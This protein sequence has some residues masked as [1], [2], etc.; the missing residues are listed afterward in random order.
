MKSS[1]SND[2]GLLNINDK[3]RSR[4]LADKNAEMIRIARAALSIEMK[5]NIESMTFAGTSENQKHWH[6]G[7]AEGMKLALMYLDNDR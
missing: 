5:E 3:L 7:M 2:T 6:E 4:I 1:S